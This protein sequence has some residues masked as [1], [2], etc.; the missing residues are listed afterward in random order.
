[1]INKNLLFNAIQDNL[2]SLEKE[3]SS[4]TESPA[5]LIH[6]MSQHLIQAGG[7]RLR[8]ALYLLCASSGDKPTAERLA[9]ATAIELIHMATLVH[10]DVIDEAA[11]RRGLPTANVKW[12]NHASVLTGDYLFAKAF[13]LVAEQGTPQML[14][15]LTEVVCS[16][17]EGEILQLKSVFNPEQS[18]SDYQLRIGKK[19]AD[20]IAASC[21]L[22]GMSAGF[23]EREIV[24][25]QQ[26]GHSVGMAF[27][28]TDDILDIT[29][30]TAKL[31]KP[32]GNDLRQGVLTIPVL[33]ALQESPYREELK[34]IIL[35][36]SMSEENLK[37]GLEIVLA[38]DAVAYSY[39]QVEQYLQQAHSILPPSVNADLR[40][41]LS[42]LADFIAERRY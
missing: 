34:K 35:Q 6:E 18:E 19:T 27:Q 23:S 15:V 31:G 14:K 12:G 3:L 16:V 8:P 40:S 24:S 22:G 39:K 11:I 32:S 25:L 41:K 42:T 29:Q 20:F 38:T 10:D 37:R 33:Y 30:S 13:S 26:Y 21:K 36:K 5:D 1:M 17:C 7:K 28:I 2:T 4:I 9:V